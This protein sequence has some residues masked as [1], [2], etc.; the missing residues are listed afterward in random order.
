VSKDVSWSEL[1]F[2]IIQALGV[3]TLVISVIGLHQRK[4][5]AFL[6]WQTVSTALFIVQYILSGRVTG[7]VTYGVVVVRGLV[8]FYYKRKNL[9]PSRAVLAAFITA[10]F[11][12]A[13][14]TWQNFL[15]VVPLA[16]AVLRTYG[17][18]QDDMKRV[19]KTS[20]VSQF[21]MIVY[22]FSAAM[23]TGALTEICNLISTLAAVWRYDV[24]E[25]TTIKKNTT[26]HRFR[27]ILGRQ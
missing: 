4:K 18:W 23:Y 26:I 16:A 12:T 8:F 11:I 25:K 19:R 13:Y 10:L 9:R 20:C 21:G 7:A 22:N 27:S 1:T 14:F 15:S 3:A 5:E 2:Y 6:I 17:T 24:R